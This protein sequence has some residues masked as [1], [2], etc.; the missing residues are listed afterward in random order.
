MNYKAE[1][2]DNID[3]LDEFDKRLL[4]ACKLPFKRIKENKKLLDHQ[5]FEFVYISAKTEGNTYTKAEAI[6]LLEKGLTAGG[7]PFYDAKMLQNIKNAFDEFVLNPKEITKDIIKDIHFMLNDGILEKQKLGI[8]RNESVLIKGANYIPPIGREF[9]D[10]EINY[11]LTQ[12]NKIK[13]PFMKAIYLHN[14][15]AYIQPFIDGNK[16]T[17]RIIQAMVL[18]YYDIMPLISKESYIS[19]Y[20]D[21]LIEYYETG[22]YE[23]YITYFRSAYEEQYNFLKQVI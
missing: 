4:N 13:E 15:I 23:K 6:T 1:Y 7:K 18:S 19:L 11:L 5:E 17:A 12:I 16:R 22:S 3:F 9:I 21:S 20:L 2:L 14:N 10:S 8:F